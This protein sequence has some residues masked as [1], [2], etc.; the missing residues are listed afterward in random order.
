MSKQF[1]PWDVD[2]AWL[3]PPSVRELVPEDHLA[4]FVR[5]TVRESLDLTAVFASYEGDDGQPPFHPAMMV[6]LLLYAYSQGV[7][8]SR[9]IAQSCEN[10]IDFMAVTAMEKPNFRTIALFR[11]RHLA[12]LGD[13]F[14]QVL[15][16]CSRAGLVRLGHV[17]LDGTK[18]RA[19]ASKHKAM[20]YARMQKIEPELAA[21]VKEWLRRAEEEDSSE[22]TEHGEDRRGDELPEWT[23]NRRKRLEKLQEAKK[24]LEDEARQAAQAAAER[25]EEQDSRTSKSRR[26]TGVPKGRAQR[27]FTD[28]ESRIMKTGE[29][30]QQCYNAQAAVDAEAQV[31]VA[32]GVT[33]VGNDV[34]ELEP[35]VMQIRGNLGKQ[36]KELS[37]DKGYSSESNLEVLKRERIRGYVATGKQQHG[38][39]S[40][41]KGKTPPEGTHARAMWGRLKRGGWRSRYRLRK[42]TVEPVFGQVKSARGFRQFLLR[43]LEKVRSEWALVC[44]AH[45]LLKLARA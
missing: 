32:H 27:N 15:R 22:N 11:K 33:N 17:G 16:L 9:K 10:R 35:M 21:E 12:A 8:S 40:P 6:A 45:N 5:E 14:G 26:P 44:T 43:G 42:V 24:A 25:S 34:G 39:S 18:I 23:R 36:A 2:Q 31:I 38:Q 41:T 7:Y 4:H 37:A 28:P 19:N 13:L 1:R 20:S 29:G 3:L 30:F